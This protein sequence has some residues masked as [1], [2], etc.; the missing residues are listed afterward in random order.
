MAHTKLSM[1]ETRMKFIGMSFSLRN[2]R[3][4][5]GALCINLVFL[6]LIGLTV[7]PFLYMIFSAFKPNTEIFGVPL[8][9]WPAHPTLANIAALL[10]QFPFARWFLNTAIVAFVGTFLSVALSSLA[11]FAFAKYDFRFKNVL[12]FVMLATLLIPYQVL[13]LPQFQIIRALHWFNTYQGLIIPRAVGAFGIFLMRQYTVNVPSELLDAARVDGSSEFGIWWRVVL[14]LVRPGLAVLGILAFTGFWN[15]FIWP[16]VVT[17]DTSMFVINLGISSLV[18]T[19][20]AQ[21]GILLSGA[22]LGALPIIIMFLFFQRQFLTGLTQ[23]AL[24]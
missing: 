11:G 9:F 8:T 23:G 13:L 7:F 12:F 2:G 4:Y 10:T 19:Y 15:D 22:A 24:K 1:S 18:G 5:L 20:D 21:Y 16:M 6:V 14:P 3:F 17:T